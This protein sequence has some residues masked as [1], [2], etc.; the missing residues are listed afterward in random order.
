M[1]RADAGKGVALGIAPDEQMAGLGVE[2]TMNRTAAGH[3]PD[4]DAGSD[5]DIGI[6]PHPAARAP[7]PFT[8]RR[9]GDVGRERDRHTEPPQRR[10][11]GGARPARLR[12]SQH[13][14]P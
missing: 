6:V 11:Q 13:M 5:G 2:A 12:R 4:A 3:D 10:E 1:E 14:Y 7:C 9:A 8:Q